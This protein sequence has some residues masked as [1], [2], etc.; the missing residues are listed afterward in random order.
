VTG[1]VQPTLPFEEQPALPLEF[2]Y[3][4]ALWHETD[5]RF[6]LISEIDERLADPTARRTQENIDEM[7]ATKRGLEDELVE[8]FRIMDEYNLLGEGAPADNYEGVR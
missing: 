3:Q 7:L 2:D 6:C 4:E 8:L 1:E 5:K